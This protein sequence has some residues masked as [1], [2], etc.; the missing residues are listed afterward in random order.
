M[1]EKDEQYTISRNEQSTEE[2]RLALLPK[3][4]TP[5]SPPAAPEKRDKP[6]PTVLTAAHPHPAPVPS[7]PLTGHQPPTP[8]LSTLTPKAP[9]YFPLTRQAPNQMQVLGMLLYGLLSALSIAAF[10]LFIINHP[11]VTNFVQADGTMNSQA[12]LLAASAVCLLIPACSLLCG[13]LFGSRRGI[14]VSLLA[15]GGGLLIT[16]I[17]NYLPWSNQSFLSLLGLPIAAFIVGLMYER[18]T[19]ASWWKSLFTM[20]LGSAIISSWLTLV[21]IISTLNSPSFTSALA[22]SSQPHI[23]TTELWI[24]GAVFSCLGI[25]ALTFPSVGLAGLIHRCIAARKKS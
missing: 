11:S 24:G 14:L 19:S 20:M 9:L 6:A 18:R 17:L 22:A 12:F 1:Q 15:V 5:S 10:S 3:Q 7:A 8:S 16:H 25:L 23:L 13:A 2:A 21:M 4:A